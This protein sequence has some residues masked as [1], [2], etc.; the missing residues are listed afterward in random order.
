MLKENMPEEGSQSK[1]HNHPSEGRTCI[2]KSAGH[3][4]IQAR[5]WHLLERSRVT[6][7]LVRLTKLFFNFTLV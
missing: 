3:C 5:K 6:R 7:W 2:E 4:R 1:S